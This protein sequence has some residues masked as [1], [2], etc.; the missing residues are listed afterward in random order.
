MPWTQTSQFPHPFAMSGRTTSIYNISSYF[1]LQQSTFLMLRTMINKLRTQVLGLGAISTS[2]S[3]AAEVRKTHY[4]Y[5]WSPSVVPKPHDWGRR[6]HVVGY[7]FL[8]APKDFKPSPE[9]QAFLAKEPKPIYIG[10]GSIIVKDP[11]A[12]TKTIIEGVRLSG[13]RAILAKGWGGTNVEKYPDFIFPLD[14]VPH[15][16]LFPQLTAAVHHGGAGTAAAAYRAGIPTMIVPFFGDQFFWAQRTEALGVGPRHIKVA[17]MTPENFG[18]ALK[19]M[20]TDQT[21]RKKAEILGVHIREQNGP[22]RAVHIIHQAIQEFDRF[23]SDNSNER[24]T[25]HGEL[26]VIVKNDTRFKLF[27]KQWQLKQGAWVN[28]PPDYVLPFTSADV[29]I[30]MDKLHISSIEGF[31]EYACD[32]TPLQ[33]SKKPLQKRR[34][35]SEIKMEKTA[36]PDNPLISPR[37]EGI[38]QSSRAANQSLVSDAE[39]KPIQQTATFFFTWNN[40]GVTKKYS[41]DSSN[42]LIVDYRKTMD[43][44]EFTVQEPATNITELKTLTMSIMKRELSDA[45]VGGM[46]DTD[47]SSS[48]SEVDLN[49]NGKKHTTKTSKTVTVTIQNKTDIVFKRDQNVIKHGEWMTFPP[50]RI[51]KLDTVTFIA[52]QG[53]SHVHKPTGFVASTV[54]LD[55]RKE[56]MTIFFKITT[57][58]NRL[59]SRVECSLVSATVETDEKSNLIITLEPKRLDIPANNNNSNNINNEARVEVR[60]E[61]TIE[62]EMKELQEESGK[63]SRKRE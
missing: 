8:D 48:S 4:M 5:C 54:R 42:A 6:I 22:A 30:R 49:S 24:S 59:K 43:G 36:R 23:R 10:F 35:D 47:N 61:P 57:Q 41:Y 1:V 13:Q 50:D 45:D 28:V 55:G 38:T 56:I 31:M 19:Q 53:P 58:K 9:L 16:W 14:A 40:F 7:W 2:D 34:S 52:F 37:K 12:L 25:S 11:D 32:Y 27:R 18:A 33:Q 3:N 39:M 21:M 63:N 51:P 15:D 44:I 46:D 62:Q 20:A 60:D 26:K 29:T 17:D